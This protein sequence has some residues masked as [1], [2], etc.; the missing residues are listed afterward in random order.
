VAGAGQHTFGAERRAIGECTRRRS[1][2][3]R[4]RLPAAD[5]RPVRAKTRARRRL[6]ARPVDVVARRAVAPSAARCARRPAGGSLQL[7][8]RLETSMAYGVPKR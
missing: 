4:K 8:R 3:F 5:V 6:G 7:P 1:H 2:S